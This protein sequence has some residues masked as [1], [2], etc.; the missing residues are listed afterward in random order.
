MPGSR[1]LAIDLLLGAA[2]G[3]A[4]T[5]LMDAVTTLLYE[6]EPKEV[7]E[8]ENRARGEKSAY[9]IA[10]EKAAA[11]ASR[12]LSDEMRKKLGLSIHWTLGVSSGVLYAAL[13][14]AIPRLHLASGLAYGTLF[15][16][17][18]D[19]AALTALGLTP[20]L[21]QFP[22]QT[23]ARGLAGHLVLGTTI[24]A[25]FDIADAVAE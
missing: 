5:W 11:L 18:M 16:L 2:A 22:W 25:A 8:R 20:P 1:P 12:E 3:A 13:R 19:E 9:E 10:A 17:L 6:R 14:H 15:W 24:E 23:H 7:Q 21:R 4:A